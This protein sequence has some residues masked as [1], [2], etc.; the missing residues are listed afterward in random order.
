[1][2]TAAKFRRRGSPLMILALLLGGWVTGRAATWDTPLDVPKISSTSSEVMFADNESQYSDVGEDVQGQAPQSIAYQHLQDYPVYPD[3]MYQERAMQRE[4]AGRQHTAYF[5]Y[6]FYPAGVVTAQAPIPRYRHAVARQ[7]HYRHAVSQPP[8]AT[9]V[10]YP[11]GQG[12]SSG[13]R[14]LMQEAFGVD[15]HSA[16]VRTGAAFA[17]KQSDKRAGA[18]R[19]VTNPPPF[20]A[21]PLPVSRPAVDRWSLDVYGFYRQGSSALS[22]TQGRLPIYGASQVGANLQWRARPSSSHDPRL[23]ARAYHALVS[24][25]ETEVAAGVSARPIGALPIRAFGE[26]R[27]TRNPANTDDGIAAKTDVRP[28]AYAATEIPP[29]KLPLGATLEAYAAGGYVGGNAS[30]Y[31]VD[32][33][34]AVT[35]QLL[36]LGRPG[37]S[38]A[39]LSVGGGVW[40]GAQEDANRLDVGPT[41]RVD[42]NIGEVPARLSVDYR[43]QVAGDAEPDSGVA[44]TLSTRF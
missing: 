21:Q 3:L 10:V 33:Q 43:E 2:S 37:S 27:L 40:G 15:W 39:A 19:A 5:P 18:V 20:A 7:E 35:R 29:I 17:G 11:Q 12:I 41:V 42:M 24:G 44:A 13:H 22:V 8:P 23:F 30:T 16:G 1:M 32:G 6:S 14:R 9:T 31:F 28:A 4:M 25:G 38:S 34:A 26:V 36:R